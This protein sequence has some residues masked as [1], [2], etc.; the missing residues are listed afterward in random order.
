M[1][2]AVVVFIFNDALIKLAAESMPAVQAIGVRGVF[3]TLWCALALLV[4]GTWRQMRWAAHPRMRL[5]R[6]AR[7]RL[8]HLL[9]DRAVP[10]S[11]RHRQC[12]QS[13]HAGHP[14]RAGRPDPEGGC[15]LAAL[16]RRDRRLPGR[17][18]GDPAASR[19]PQR[20]DLARPAGHGDRLLP[21]HPRALPARGHTDA[22]RVLHLGAGGGGGRLRLGGGRGLAADERPR[23]RLHRWARRSCWRW[24]TSSWSSRCARAASSR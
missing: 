13:L 5:P 3:A 7:G 15:A 11:L 12:G 10:D 6:R 21:R 17:A 2:A 22:G 9:P 1:S 14:H 19:R 24:A 20:L 4:T 16:E 18:A 23:H 8:G